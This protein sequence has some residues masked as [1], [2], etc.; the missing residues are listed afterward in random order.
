MW[1]IKQ[2]YHAKGAVEIFEENNIP[3]FVVH[4]GHYPE[5]VN[6]DGLTTR[7]EPH[8]LISISGGYRGVERSYNGVTVSA[9]GAWHQGRRRTLRVFNDVDYSGK[10]DEAT[11]E[12][13]IALG[14]SKITEA[15]ASLLSLNENYETAYKQIFA[16]TEN[17]RDPLGRKEYE[18]LCA[19]NGA[20]ILNDS[21]CTSYGVKFGDFNYPE[22]SAAHVVTMHLAR[23]RM[24][25]LDAETAAA[26]SAHAKS[27]PK[28]AIKPEGQLWE[29]CEQ[30]GAEPVYM[31]LHLCKQCWPTAD[32]E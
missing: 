32:H 13:Y 7:D 5:A 8:I 11:P 24:R 26:Q 15:A 2:N 14:K 10:G 27:H 28:Q 30:C 4:A 29:P 17:Y 18:L 9:M 6:E 25:Q 23:Q 21:D 22:Y 3:V 1:T 20:E 31:P 16:V 19:G 12:K